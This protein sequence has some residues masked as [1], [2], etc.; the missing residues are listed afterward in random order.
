MA[1]YLSKFKAKNFDFPTLL[2]T[3]LMKLG[4]KKS[5]HTIVCYHWQDILF[6]WHHDT[7]AYIRSKDVG[8]GQSV[9]YDFAAKRPNVHSSLPLLGP[10]SKNM[11]SA[12][13]DEVLVIDWKQVLSGIA[14][15]AGQPGLT[16]HALVVYGIAYP[17][18]QVAEPVA[19]E[20]LTYRLLT[21]LIRSSAVG[22]NTKKSLYSGLGVP[23][24]EIVATGY[25]SEGI[26]AKVLDY[27]HKLITKQPEDP[28]LKVRDNLYA[29]LDAAYR[30]TFAVETSGTNV[31][32]SDDQ[33]DYALGVQ[34][35]GPYSECF[36]A[37]SLSQ[38][39]RKHL[40]FSIKPLVDVRAVIDASCLTTK[41]DLPLMLYPAD[42]TITNH[43][44]SYMYNYFKLGLRLGTADMAT[45]EANFL[46][47]MG[48]T[49][50]APYPRAMAVN[51][52]VWAD[53]RYRMRARWYTEEVSG[54]VTAHQQ[55]RK[56]Y[57]LSGGQKPTL[58]MLCNLVGDP[59]HE[60]YEA[61]VKDTRNA[62]Y[63]D[64]WLR[65]RSVA[66]ANNADKHD[67]L[68]KVSGD[69]MEE[70]FLNLRIAAA[71]RTL[72]VRTFKGE[73]A[74]SLVT[75][76][77][78][79][80]THKPRRERPKRWVMCLKRNT[81]IGSGEHT[82]KHMSDFYLVMHK[83]ER[84]ISPSFVDH[85]V[86]DSAVFDL[87][88]TIKEYQKELVNDSKIV[89]GHPS[90]MPEYQ[91]VELQTEIVKYTDIARML[92]KGHVV[93]EGRHYW[94]TTLL[95][96]VCALAYPDYV[97]PDDLT[98]W[99]YR[100]RTWFKEKVRIYRNDLKLANV[101]KPDAFAERGNL[102]GIGFGS[103]E[104]AVIRNLLRPGVKRRRAEWEQI[105]TV[106]AFH[107]D[108]GIY[109]RAAILRKRMIEEEGIYDLDKLPHQ[110]VTVQLRVMIK[111]AQ[112]LL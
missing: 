32:G 86:V 79:I 89:R 105:K 107:K 68:V 40:E 25:P 21:A 39:K 90:K 110:Q 24:S 78:N 50:A 62:Q 81:T 83:S 87:R 91:R 4:S 17:V 37:V 42:T 12:N 61:L 95:Q 96:K 49:C 7:K 59:K 109:A 76:E 82:Q 44:V 53:Q 67:L 22:D 58:G 99:R 43:E 11:A 18:L 63:W 60:V 10:W 84:V 104:D 66:T 77:T 65:E 55:G 98:E 35:H 71:K 103:D 93:V 101:T 92:D 31:L 51:V 3:M 9:A 85:E 70:L 100:T 45:H 47:P 52:G 6:H 88:R 28:T 23:L 20:E 16:A 14:D 29:R 54:K 38:V 41:R 102:G 15:V 56:Y 13:T 5:L 64:H 72:L 74:N 69:A 106:C 97:L 75:K 19:A 27:H 57:Y 1:E 73:I 94:E 46:A 48:V 112:G 80:P 26:M 108:R 2:S 8:K 36:S 33:Y 34:R 111:K 30:L